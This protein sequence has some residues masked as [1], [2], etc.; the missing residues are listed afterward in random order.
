M[1][2]KLGA[3]EGYES[4]EVQHTYITLEGKVGGKAVYAWPTYLPQCLINTPSSQTSNLPGMRRKANYEGSTI[5]MFLP[6][7]KLTMGGIAQTTISY[8]RARRLWVM[9][10]D[11]A[12]CESITMGKG[13]VRRTRLITGPATGVTRCMGNRFLFHELEG[14]LTS[15]FIDNTT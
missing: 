6:R 12:A 8:F 3:R 5:T 15:S 1:V 2:G 7:S 13:G 10:S 9:I 11:Q 14:Y 4:T